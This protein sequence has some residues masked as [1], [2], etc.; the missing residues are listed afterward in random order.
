MSLLTHVQAWFKHQAIEPRVLDNRAFLLGL[1]E[2]YRT[3]MQ[4]HERT[5][6]LACA[7]AVARALTITAADVPV[8]GYYA[9]DPSLTEYFRLV[10]ALQET[11]SGRAKEVSGLAEFRRL[12]EV[13]SA[14][15]Y[16]HPVDED[17]LLPRGRDPLSEALRQL[18]PDWTVP[19]LTAGAY[20]AA[21]RNDDYSLVGLAARVKDPVVLAALRESV[22][23]Y[24]EPL[25]GSAMGPMREPEI[26]WRVD[27]DLAHQA[28][29]FVD[30]FNALFGRELPPPIPK[31]AAW[32]WGAYLEAEIL[33]RCVRLGQSLEP[34]YYHWAVCRL[35]AGPLTVHDFWHGEIWT[36]ARYR[37]ALARDG[38]CP[39]L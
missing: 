13:C 29:R 23:L 6:L 38:R 3:A 10:R 39:G 17:T 14:P 30:A 28:G 25:V 12:R 7:R 1:D 33:G 37:G 22:V 27:E 24:A 19:Q 4:P 8:E 36:T 34:R 21:I 5:E 15:L 35:P 26:L 16:G 9:D 11:A 20:A 31:Y 2:L 32:Y 18:W